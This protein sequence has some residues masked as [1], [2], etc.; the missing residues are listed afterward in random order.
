MGVE[1]GTAAAKQWS[2]DILAFHPQ[3]ANGH[4]LVVLLV[5]FIT[6]RATWILVYR[7][8]FSPLAKF[9]GPKRAAASYLYEAYC[10]LVAQGGGQMTFRIKK[11]HEK[12]GPIVRINPDELHIDDPEYFN[13]IFCNSHTSKPIDKSERFKYRF[14]V[15]E[16]T[17]STVEFEKH[18]MRRAAI[19]PFFSKARIKSLNGKLTDIT[20]RI[21]YRLSSEYA[22][23]GRVINVSDMWATMTADVITELAFARSTD[24]SAA[25]DFKSPYSQAMASSVFYAHH[26]THFDWLRAAMNWMPDSVLGTLMPPFKPILEYRVA[27]RS[28]IQDMLLGRNM[29][30]KEASHLTIFHDILASDLPAEEV[31][32]DR[33]VQE[34]MS[35]NGAGIETTMWALTVATFHVLWNPS[36]EA[37]L[38]A[39]LTTAM[40][41]PTSMLTWEE[42]ENLPY[43]SGVIQEALR[44]GFGSVQRLPRVNRLGSWKYRDWEIPPNVSVSMDAYHNHINEDIF[45]EPLEFRPERWLNDPKGPD[46]VHP[47]SH[48]M[49]AFARGSRNCVGMHLALMELYVALATLFRRHHLELFE[50]DRS[51]VDFIVDLVKPMPKWGSKG[52]RVVV[53]K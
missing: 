44:L 18:R 10:D 50:T 40:P 45:P 48:Y 38:R 29:D 9:P 5:A 11:M 17:V 47:L 12:Y 24:F 1:M 15:P 36:I 51:D 27:I 46:G 26:T 30:A 53:V 43:L 31:A 25:P 33:L 49:V 22:G 37:R 32:F 8:Y 39:E 41:D 28:Q 2:D 19:S 3:Q 13:E 21:S 4:V 42:L 34:A 7:L 16:A 20:E 23:T 6:A 52:V 35:V 14:N